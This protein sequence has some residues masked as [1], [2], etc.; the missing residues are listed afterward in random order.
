VVE[1]GKGGGGKRGREGEYKTR[2]GKTE[3]RRRKRTD[4]MHTDG[5]RCVG[6]EGDHE[7]WDAEMFLRTQI[8]TLE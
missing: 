4:E 7:K 2:R 3:R 1:G 5:R 6:D 8:P